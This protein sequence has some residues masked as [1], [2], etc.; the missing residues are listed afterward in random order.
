VRGGEEG[1]GRGWGGT[2]WGGKRKAGQQVV[3]GIGEVGEGRGC[4]PQS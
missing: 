2:G 3:A 4:D 1:V